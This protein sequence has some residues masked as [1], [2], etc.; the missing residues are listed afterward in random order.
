MNAEQIEKLMA[1]MAQ[2]TQ[3]SADNKRWREQESKDRQ[4]ADE[5]HAAESKALHEEL[6]AIK[7]RLAETESKLDARDNNNTT[8]LGSDTT[9][10]DKDAVPAKT[11]S[12]SPTLKQEPGTDSHGTSDSDT[13]DY[14][15]NEHDSVDQTTIIQLEKSVIQ[16]MGGI[17]SKTAKHSGKI[18]DH[19]KW[20]LN[21][22]TAL[23]AVSIDLAIIDEAEPH[24]P[25]LSP[26]AA[27]THKSVIARVL[28]AV[29]KEGKPYE[30]LESARTKKGMTDV[31]SQWVALR[32]AFHSSEAS[33]SELRFDGYLRALQWK[34]GGDPAW[35]KDKIMAI[36][37]EL[38][39][40][41][42][43][44]GEQCALS[45]RKCAMHFRR[46]MCASPDYTE[47]ERAQLH[48]L[49]EAK[50]AY[51][52]EKVL[53]GQTTYDMDAMIEI[54]Q[55][56]VE[57]EREQKAR[58]GQV[59]QQQQQQD[60][61]RNNGKKKQPH[62]NWKPHSSGEV[63]RSFKLGR[64][65]F[66]DKCRH[67]HEG[68]ASNDNG[69][70]NSRNEGKPKRNP[71]AGLM[72]LMQQQTE[73]QKQLVQALGSLKQQ[74][75][76]SADGDHDTMACSWADFIGTDH[77]QQGVAVLDGDAPV[78]PMETKAAC[79]GISTTVNPFDVLSD[80]SGY[81]S[82][83]STDYY[84]PFDEFDAPVGDNTS[85]DDHRGEGGINR[86]H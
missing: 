56:T 57:R 34:K 18:T 78:P 84:N 51:L 62:K 2:L 1:S 11:V 41:Q 58:Q 38:D 50:C 70:R 46:I 32:D 33:T 16:Q 54:V 59:K 17:T 71:V 7:T 45:D 52:E 27:R 35:L 47:Q 81:S 72:Q 42:A 37:L 29:V 55:S 53:Q 60:R 64:C 23:Q 10:G 15:A 30:K 25:L 77:H 63:C 19:H 44:S 26:K 6:S 12:V 3:E 22:R 14:D 73:T 74:Q 8:S 20:K 69:S 39:G 9:K 66:G 48:M 49:F 21:F 86:E 13:S 40:V 76:A 28:N 68:S 75:A 36:K 85:V 4:A 31:H 79:E 80:N 83:D 43:A 65:K 82:G 24:L 5:R 61:A 67:I